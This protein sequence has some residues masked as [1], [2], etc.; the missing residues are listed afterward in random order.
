MAGLSLLLWSLPWIV[1]GGYIVL[2]VR[3]P[4]PLPGPPRGGPPRARSSRPA[5]SVI[6]PAR[7]E[8]HNIGACVG[9]IAASDYPDFELIIVDDQSHDGTGARAR[10]IGRGRATRLLVVEGELVP[11]G[12]FGKQWACWQGARE[13]RGDL[14]L[15]T[16]ADTVHGSGLL[17]RAVAELDTTGGDALTVIG[18]Q[19]MASFWEQL[20]QPQVF[21]LLAL[22]YPRMGVALP[23]RR[24]RRAIANGQYLLFRQDAYQE[25]GGHAAVRYEAAEDLRLAQRLVAGGCRLIVRSAHRDLATRMYRGLGEVVAGWSKNMMQAGLRTVP[26]MLRPCAAP[27][28]LLSGMVIW[29]APPA[30][31]GAALLGMGET[32]LLAW[33]AGVTG[34]SMLFWT[35]WGTRFGA[36]AWVGPLYP[37]GAV[38]GHWILLRS[39]LGRSR[40]EWKGRSYAWD[41]YA[42]VSEESAA[43]GP[44]RARWR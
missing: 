6:V 19:T 13:A 36:P 15:F 21:L 39:W 34:C 32:V 38:V 42:D 3:E 17:A 9:S 40:V 5:V 43:P 1:L 37:L 26:Q 31:F 24:W 28:M 7:N 33:S 4:P 11:P 22:R 10:G 27:L 25:I 41:V 8:A 44:T 23:A 14:L 2:G 12:W 30:A 18:R 35:W 16:D 20:V 29:L